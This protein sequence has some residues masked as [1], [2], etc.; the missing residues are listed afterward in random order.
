M[1]TTTPVTADDL[2]RLP[3]DGNRYELV[4]GELRMMS[5]SG[6]KHGEVVANL[7]GIL[8]QHVRHN[9]LGKMFGAETGFLITRD[10]DTVRA[11]DIAFISQENLPEEEPAEAYWPHATDLVVEVVSP[12]D[13]TGDVDDKIRAWLDAGTQLVWVVDPKLQTVTSYQPDTNVKLK[14]AGQ[15]LDGGDVVVGFSCAID[16]IFSPQ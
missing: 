11:P 7:H 14:A 10:P 9:R 15:H 13:T 3:N 1:S 8:W 6:W 12:R 4:A 16:E 2:L 5:P